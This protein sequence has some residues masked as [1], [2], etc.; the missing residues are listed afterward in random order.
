[1]S[2]MKT[3][4]TANQ[5]KAKGEAC[6][7]FESLAAKAI[8]GNSVCVRWYRHVPGLASRE[9]NR[10]CATRIVD[11]WR[12]KG[13]KTQPTCEGIARGLEMVRPGLAVI[14]AGEP[15]LATPQR[16]RV[17]WMSAPQTFGAG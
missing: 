10:A 2:A 13:F 7:S 5:T 17:V 11:E 1:M 15:G 3:N 9:E 6:A 12:D 8:S 16:V 14:V 4:K